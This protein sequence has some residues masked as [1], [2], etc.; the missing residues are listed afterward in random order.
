MTAKRHSTSHSKMLLLSL[1]LNQNEP[2][3]IN[4]MCDVCIF[5]VD[6]AYKYIED[7][8]NEQAVEEFLDGVCAVLPFDVFNWCE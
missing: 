5:V 6:A 4:I 7:P 8:T 2:T 1:I 3:K